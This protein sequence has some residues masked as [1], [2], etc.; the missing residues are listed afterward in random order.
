MTGVRRVWLVFSSVLVLGVLTETVL[1]DE[2][3]LLSDNPHILGILFAIVAA[4]LAL[5]YSVAESFQRLAQR[6]HQIVA[7]VLIVWCLA[8]AIGEFFSDGEADGWPLFIA[9][10]SAISGAVA[11]SLCT[12]R[13]P[14][15][16]RTVISVAGILSLLAYGLVMMRM[17][18]VM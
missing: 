4:G 6:R 10:G 1:L 9:I 14:F 2:N 15:W 13:L 18:A 11:W 3:P 12:L 8:F 16:L 7:A 5:V 17:N